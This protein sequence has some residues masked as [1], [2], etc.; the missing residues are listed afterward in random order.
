MRDD[1][2]NLYQHFQKKK[3]V[4]NLVPNYNQVGPKPNYHRYIEGTI[5]NLQ[6]RFCFCHLYIIN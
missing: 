1:S 2:K 3:I 5:S 4:M 6:K